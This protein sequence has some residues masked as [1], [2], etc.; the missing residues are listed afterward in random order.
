VAS[1]GDAKAA[2]CLQISRNGT[3]KPAGASHSRLQ[4]PRAVR[5]A[6]NLAADRFAHP[7]RP[8]DAST[9]R[10]NSGTLARC[11][12]KDKLSTAIPQ[13]RRIMAVPWPLAHARGGV[14]SAGRGARRSSVGCGSAFLW[15]SY[16]RPIVTDT[17]AS[18]GDPVVAAERPPRIPESCQNNRS[19]SFHE[20]VLR[21]D[22]TGAESGL[23]AGTKAAA[24]RM[25][26]RESGPG[27]QPE[28]D[29][30]EEGARGPEQDALCPNSG[31]RIP[32]THPTEPALIVQRTGR[33]RSCS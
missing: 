2:I 12:A 30:V 13:Q 26:I 20:F 33:A 28:R 22:P 3:Q 5:T 19:T 24:C 32:C 15:W 1:P 11:H 6:D 9:A 27:D 21:P 31:G 25:V 29:R 16:P 7:A 23:K 17:G 10:P 18:G 14:F 4:L 8:T